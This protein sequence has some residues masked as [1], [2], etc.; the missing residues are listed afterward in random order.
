ML[1]VSSGNALTNRIASW[2]L[3][4]NENHIFFWHGC[5]FCEAHASGQGAG[6]YFN[7]TMT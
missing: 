4:Q 6:Q 5:E 1:R 3:E 2:S 7:N